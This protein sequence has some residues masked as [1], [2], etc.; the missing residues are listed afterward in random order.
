MTY[1]GPVYE[2]GTPPPP[3]PAERPHLASR[4][5]RTVKAGASFGTALAM[6]ISWSQHESIL[7][8][9]VHGILSWVYV[10]YYAIVR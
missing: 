7:W 3:G 4:T 8:A 10:A 1:S 9:I 5:V 6:V 2:P